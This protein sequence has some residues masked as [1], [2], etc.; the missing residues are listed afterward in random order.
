VSLNARISPNNVKK[1]RKDLKHDA[2]CVESFTKAD[3][4][5]ASLAMS[6]PGPNAAND[7]CKMFALNSTP[8]ASSHLLQTALSCNATTGLNSTSNTASAHK[9]LPTSY[10]PKDGQTLPD[11]VDCKSGVLNWPGAVS[12]ATG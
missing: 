6:S 2:C 1:K 9:M 4:S 8:N 12:R 11:G 5:Q 10:S 3:R 7:I